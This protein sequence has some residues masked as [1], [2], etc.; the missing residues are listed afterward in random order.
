M[1][2]YYKTCPR[3]GS[4]NDSGEI[5]D[6]KTNPDRLHLSET[7]VVGADIAHRDDYSVVQVSKVKGGKMI[8]LKSYYGKAAEELYELLT[9]RKINK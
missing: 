2:A 8:Y 5:C 6:C 1:A 9:G 3:C 4:N 7:L